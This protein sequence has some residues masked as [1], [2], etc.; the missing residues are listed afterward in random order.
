M[1]DVPGSLPFLRGFSTS[2]LVKRIPAE[3][4]VQHLTG[5][6]NMFA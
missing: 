2:A 6:A 1:G 3:G 5:S 4:D